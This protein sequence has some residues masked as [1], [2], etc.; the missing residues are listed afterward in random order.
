MTITIDLTLEEEMRLQQKAKERGTDVPTLIHAVLSQATE[1]D[2]TTEIQEKN[3]GLLNLFQ[4]WREEDDALTSE[5]LEANSRQ[6]QELK[7]ALNDN[8]EEEGRLP[9]FHENSV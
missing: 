4:E 6:W 1:R 5:E 7:Q 9:V 8:R 2:T 3:A